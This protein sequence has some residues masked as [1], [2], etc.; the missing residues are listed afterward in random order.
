MKYFNY[1]VILIMELFMC[2]FQAFFTFF[3]TIVF[4]S[5]L[6]SIPENFVPFNDSV[7]STTRARFTVISIKRQ[8][9]G[10]PEF[11]TPT[12]LAAYPQLNKNLPLGAA[13][14]IELG[15]EKHEIELA[16]IPN[17]GIPTV[18]MPTGA[19][20]ELNNFIL[21]LLTGLPLWEPNQTS[22]LGYMSSDIHILGNP[23]AVI[24]REESWVAETPTN[25]T[26]RFWSTV[27]IFRKDCL[28]NICRSNRRLMDEVVALLFNDNLGDR[29]LNR[30][31]TLSTLDLIAELLRYTLGSHV[32][33]T[34]PQE[35][36]IAMRFK[37]GKTVVDIPKPDCVSTEEAKKPYSHVLKDRL[38]RLFQESY[39]GWDSERK[40]L[41]Y[42]FAL[43]QQNPP[44]SQWID[45]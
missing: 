28:E 6:L 5:S 38:R 36:S 14:I 7:I 23:Q 19:P 21:S 9:V 32:V 3:F 33:E 44:T 42:R 12:I 17:T 39:L 26:N 30:G 4:S 24:G 34:S 35:P 2:Y 20:L 22:K 15:E 8:K 40:L 25:L 18:T 13:K 29:T 43:T 11:I 45:Q 16:F 31:L 1:L 41:T 37:L 27:W 10:G